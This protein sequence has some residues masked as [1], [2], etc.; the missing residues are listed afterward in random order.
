[1][2]ANNKGF[3]KAEIAEFKKK[4]SAGNGL[5]IINKDEE[6]SEDYVNFF[7]VGKYQGRDVIYDA[8]LYTLR[9]HH[10]SE[11][12]EIAEH[13]AAKR[14]PEFKKIEYEEDEFGDI[15]TL[16]DLEEEIGL[17]MSEKM[18][19]MEEEGT[20]KVKEFIEVDPNLSYGIGLDASLNVES[21]TDEVIREFIEK[22]NEDTLEL[23]ET[24]YSFEM[25]EDMED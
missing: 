9:L 12:Y 14:F 5:Y 11:M 25:E 17:F 22:Y 7:F 8:V 16:D 19:E 24:L 18:M 20:V 1:M 23:D 13:E 4:L 3:D 2:F 21:I 10:Q 15:K 6:N